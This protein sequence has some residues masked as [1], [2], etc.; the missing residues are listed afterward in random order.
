MV[1]INSCKVLQD[2]SLGHFYQN[3]TTLYSGICRRR[4]HLNHS[5]NSCGGLDRGL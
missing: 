2:D 5:K 3:V 4:E 1:T